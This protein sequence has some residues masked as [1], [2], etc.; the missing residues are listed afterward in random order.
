MAAAPAG[1]GTEA[2]P[3]ARPEVLLERGAGDIGDRHATPLGLVAKPGVEVVGSFTVV[4][5]MGMPAYHFDFCLEQIALTS[6]SICE[7]S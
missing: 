3:P 6:K 7:S 5:R 4:R 1:G 2:S